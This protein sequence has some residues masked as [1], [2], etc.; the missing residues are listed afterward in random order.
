[1]FLVGAPAYQ[2]VDLIIKGFY[3][4]N[5]ANPSPLGILVSPSSK[6]QDLIGV[7]LSPK[8]AC[9]FPTYM[10]SASP[11]DKKPAPQTSPMPMGPSEAPPAL[12]G[13]STLPMCLSKGPPVYYHIATLT[14]PALAFKH[15]NLKGSGKGCFC[16]ECDKTSSKCNTI[17]S[18]HLQEFLR[19]L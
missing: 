10:I 18:Y 5:E 11:K 15:I 16:G 7:E 6:L 13:R 3:G 4:P 9:Y 12:S 17:E 2:L 14:I 8:R 1:M 19:D